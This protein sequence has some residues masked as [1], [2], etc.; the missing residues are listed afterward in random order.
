MCQHSVD[1]SLSY[2]VRVPCWGMHRDWLTQFDTSHQ[3]LAAML[4]LQWAAT[5]PPKN[6]PSGP[7][8]ISTPPQPNPCF[9]GATR[10]TNPNDILIS[11][12]VFAGLTNVINRQTQRPHYS[13]CS[14]RP[15]SL[16]AMQPNNSDNNV[17]IYNNPTTTYPYYPRRL[18]SHRHGQGIQSRLSVCLSAL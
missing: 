1:I 16:D 17:N 4:R 3:C 18:Y 5:F 11:S 7:G 9:L 13:M 6:A 12:T 10:V 15:L 14:N 8:W 2:C